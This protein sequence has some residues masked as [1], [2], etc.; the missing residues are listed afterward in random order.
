MGG[1]GI[2]GDPSNNGKKYD[3][4]VQLFIHEKSTFNPETVLQ[5]SDYRPLKC[6]YL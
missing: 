1:T 4:S 5:C 3:L 2:P 6:S